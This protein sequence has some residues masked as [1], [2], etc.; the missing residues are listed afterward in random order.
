MGLEEPDID[1]EQLLNQG[2]GSSSSEPEDISN[3]SKKELYD[4]VMREGQVRL[5]ENRAIIK[6]PKK[7]TKWQD[8]G[9]LAGGPYFKDCKYICPLSV[10]PAPDGSGKATVCNG[11]YFGVG[12]WRDN[13]EKVKEPAREPFEDCPYSPH[14]FEDDSNDDP[15][16]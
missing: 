12:V 15:F 11:P 4:K 16:E 6:C 13:G 7:E 9:F 3:L 5:G 2:S 1:I 8:G 14:R 10:R